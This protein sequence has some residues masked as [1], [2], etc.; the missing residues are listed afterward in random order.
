[1]RTKNAFGILVALL[2]VI[3][4]CSDIF[5]I[6]EFPLF[7]SQDPTIPIII[8]CNK[9]KPKSNNNLNYISKL[10]EGQ[11]YEK[12]D[13]S[14][15]NVNGGV[16]IFINASKYDKNHT[17]GYNSFVFCPIPKSGSSSWKKVL[18]RMKGI[19]LYLADDY[20]SL[21][22]KLNKLNNDTITHFGTTH[23]TNIL[24]NENIIHTVFIR[25]SIERAISAFLDKCVASHWARKFWCKPRT[26]KTQLNT[27]KK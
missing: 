20:W 15:F 23:A 27:K 2:I 3:I 16:P 6:E 1:M 19:K 5:A 10:I 13:F 12:D 14:F 11:K 17:I 18:R 26:Q 21:L 7:I 24:Y 8:E 25:D 4:I 22:S 9:K